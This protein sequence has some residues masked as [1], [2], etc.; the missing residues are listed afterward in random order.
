[1][2]IIWTVILLPGFSCNIVRERK[3]AQKKIPPHED[4]AP[5]FQRLLV[6]AVCCFVQVEAVETLNSDKNQKLFSSMGVFT[7][8]ELE[9]RQET[10]FEQYTNALLI[11]ASCMGEMVQTGALRC[12][13]KFAP[14]FGFQVLV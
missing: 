8:Q 9:G 1:M 6:R 4:A 5:C 14:S 13:A 3:G 11:E 10:M 7:P 2:D 12:I